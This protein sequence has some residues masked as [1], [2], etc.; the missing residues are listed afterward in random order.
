MSILAR[1]NRIRN[2]SYVLPDILRSFEDFQ[3]FHNLDLRSMD[4]F[5]LWQEMFKVKM[6]LANIDSQ[7]QPWLFV[8]PGKFIPAFEWLK[9]RYK[10]IKAELKKRERESI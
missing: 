5:S 3:R 8:E 1:K 4:N 9:Y 6:A 7:R 2:T 10:A